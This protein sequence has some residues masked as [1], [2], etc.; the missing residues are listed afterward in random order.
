MTTI[1]KGALK[2]YVGRTS[3]KKIQEI[4]KAVEVHLGLCPQPVADA[5]QART[6]F[7]G[8]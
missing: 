7:E 3:E 4:E 5:A 1:G 6:I 2:N 8:A